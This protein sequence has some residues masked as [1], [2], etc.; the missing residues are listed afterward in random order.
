MVEANPGVEQRQRQHVATHVVEVAR[1][2]RGARR[3]AAATEDAA[4]QEAK[5][6]ARHSGG[7]DDPPADR[8]IVRR[9]DPPWRHL[10]RTRHGY[11]ALDARRVEE[12]DGDIE[13]PTLQAQLAQI[14]P[15][16][17]VA[18]DALRY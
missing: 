9:A 10:R 3:P 17:V 4:L 2:Q 7:L 12:W 11:D 6:V 16:D 8:P 15:R 5:L 14:E 1:P 13:E 18:D